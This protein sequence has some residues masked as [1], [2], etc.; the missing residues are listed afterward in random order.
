MTGDFPWKNPHRFD[1]E[2]AGYEHMLAVG[3]GEETEILVVVYRLHQDGTREVLCGLKGDARKK[4]SVPSVPVPR[5]QA[6]EILDSFTY[7]AKLVVNLNHLRKEI[8]FLLAK[9]GLI[10]G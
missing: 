8:I 1:S 6:I 5:K 7:P 10:K 2:K 9:A 4:T 3:F